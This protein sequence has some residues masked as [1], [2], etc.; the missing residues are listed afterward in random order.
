MALHAQLRVT[1]RK[2]AQHSAS[3]HP[4]AIPSVP[5]PRANIPVHFLYLRDQ[6]AG[7]VDGRLEGDAQQRRQQ[8]I[9]CLT[10]PLKNRDPWD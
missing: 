3:C 4:S 2:R 7:K 6:V 9:A 10:R 5:W 8:S 1:Y